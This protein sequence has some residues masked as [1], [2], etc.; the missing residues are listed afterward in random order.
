MVVKQN[1]HIIVSVRDVYNMLG[2]SG[3]GTV[4]TTETICII[5]AVTMIMMVLMKSLLWTMWWCT[6]ITIIDLSILVTTFTIAWG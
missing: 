2:T 1:L 3:R 4:R 5:I 6:V